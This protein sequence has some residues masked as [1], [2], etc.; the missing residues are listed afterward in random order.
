MAGPASQG[1]LLS[2]GLSHPIDGK[3]N[4]ACPLPSPR[5]AE[6]KDRRQ[7]ALPVPCPAEAEVHSRKSGEGAPAVGQSV[8]TTAGRGSI[9]LRS[10]DRTCVGSQAKGDIGA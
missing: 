1:D 8:E 3:I 7:W 10:A 9:S 6:E 4:L 5:D 2:V